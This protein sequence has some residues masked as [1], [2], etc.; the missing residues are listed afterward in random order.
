VVSHLADLAS[1]VFSAWNAIILGLLKFYHLSQFT[2]YLLAQG[3]SAAL[4][5]IFQYPRD[6]GNSFIQTL[7][8]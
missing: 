5:N 1:A 7:K 6:K 3:W 4:S 2:F 8:R